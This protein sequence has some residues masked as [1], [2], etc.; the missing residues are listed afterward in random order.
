MWQLLFSK[1]I[2]PMF[3]KPTTRS[4]QN[5]FTRVNFPLP[6]EEQGTKTRR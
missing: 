4:Q 5:K 3:Y 1:C 6:S 2:Y